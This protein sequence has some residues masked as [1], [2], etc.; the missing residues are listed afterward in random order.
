MTGANGFY[1]RLAAGETCGIAI[2]AKASAPGR[3]KTRLVPPLTFDEAAAIN[4]AFLQDI[5]GNVLLAGQHAG[6]AGYAAF[7]PRGS[8][9]FFSR[10]L[11]PAIGLI[12][13][14]LPNFGDCLLRTVEEILERR[15]ASTGGRPRRARSVERRRILFVGTENRTSA[16]VRGHRL[17]H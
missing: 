11:P 10:I 6:I 9:D 12:D 16:H 8:E 4:T 1:G 15:S 7:A 17:E 14:C 5:V 13:A 3:T 2:M